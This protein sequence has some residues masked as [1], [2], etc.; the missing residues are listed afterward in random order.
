M[1]S[2]VLDSLELDINKTFLHVDDLD[3]L[4]AEVKLQFLKSECQQ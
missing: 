2:P 1:S 4:P 3:L